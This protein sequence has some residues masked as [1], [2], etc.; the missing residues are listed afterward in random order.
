MQFEHKQSAQ[1]CRDSQLRQIYGTNYFAIIPFL[2]NKY[3]IL[4]NCLDPWHAAIVKSLIAME[5][6]IECVSRRLILGIPVQHNSSD[7]V[8]ECATQT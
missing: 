1:R 7:N 2:P 8:L 3:H 5:S 6:Y 4:A